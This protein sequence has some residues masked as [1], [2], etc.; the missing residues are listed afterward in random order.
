MPR[1]KASL[2]A[3]RAN[4]NAIY[5]TTALQA[6]IDEQAGILQADSKD[7][8][9]AFSYFFEAFEAH[10]EKLGSKAATA[11]SQVKASQCLK[12]MLLCKVMMG[13]AS[14]VE[15]IVSGKVALKHEGRNIDSIR[16]VASAYKERSLHSL[17]TAL[18]EYKA[19]L[20]EDDLIRLHLENLTETLLEEN[21]LRLIEPYSWWVPAARCKLCWNEVTFRCAGVLMVH[22]MLLSAT[23]SKLRTS[24]SSS[25]SP[26]F[27]W[28]PSSRR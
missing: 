13:K 15:S 24:P 25:T 21:L 1:A 8:K 9:T 3:A 20:M 16:A 5:M 2:T 23:A 17:E 11:S 4:A 19:E 22:R 18:K 6:K 14:D 10:D 12:Y 28:S 7:F 26:W 27:A